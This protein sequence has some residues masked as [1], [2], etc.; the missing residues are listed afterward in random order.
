MSRVIRWPVVRR[1]RLRYG[2]V[3]LDAEPVVWTCRRPLD[4]RNYYTNY[5]NIWCMVDDTARRIVE[6]L[7][8]RIGDGLRTV[9]ILTPSEWEGAY[10]RED[11]KSDYD[12]ATYEQTVELFRDTHD[13]ELPPE[14]AEH[15]G[16]RHAIV[17]YHEHAFVFQFPF[18]E[19]E[20]ILV[21][22]EADVGREL[23]GFIEAC[24]QIIQGETG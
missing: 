17:H 3:G 14:S 11:L 6:Y 7:Q 20:T 10:L 8:D 9:V 5:G 4:S 15:I 23:L 12:E 2:F 19:T 16:Q 1:R 18:S 22:V 24:R 13:V 21:S